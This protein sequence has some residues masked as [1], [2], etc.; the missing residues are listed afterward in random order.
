ML[1]AVDLFKEYRLGLNT[2]QVLK[3]INLTVNQGEILGIVGPSGAGKSTLLHLLGG[4]DEPT[5]GKVALE[6]KDISK[7][8]DRQ[9]A[10]LRNRHFGF[11]F[12]FY[13]LLAEFT[14]VENV[15]M[16]AILRNKETRNKIKER[17][18]DI[19]NR[20]GL[21][22]RLNHRP[23]ELSGGEQ[24]RVAIAR[25][26]INMPQILL[27]DE[28]TGNLDTETGLQIKSLLWRLN[29][30]YNMTL[31]IVTHAQEL[32]GDASRIIHLKD[33]RIINEDAT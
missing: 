14:A 32:V 18:S 20:C 19:L 5:R 24:Q 28:P 30:E 13:H 16:P 2:L 4:L 3:E 9:R 10:Q 23:S 7:H 21:S 33:G 26:L 29:K 1:E 15:M 17:S 6:G 11:V 31:I 25:A 8:N 22:E 12:Q 27:C